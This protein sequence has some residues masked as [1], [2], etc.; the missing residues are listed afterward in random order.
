LIRKLLKFTG[1]ITVLAIL[2][3]GSLFVVSP[4]YVYQVFNQELPVGRLE[5][6]LTDELEYLAMLTEGSSCN[7]TQYRIL[8]DQF[9]LD[10]G[11]VKW[12][13]PAVLLGFKP[14]YRLDRL[15][16]RY[17]E[18]VQ[19]NSM[20]TLAHDL[21]PDLLFDFFDD[22][23]SD[24]ENHWLID[25]TYGSSVYHDIDPLLTYTILATEDGL[26]LRTTPLFEY[27]SNSD[28]LVIGISSACA[29]NPH[30]KFRDILLDMNSI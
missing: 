18:T 23:N 24:S 8:G 3:V 25:T 27:E 2:S 29:N 13:G 7:Q 1:V 19:Q 30:A 10:A 11:F 14:R 4:F 6:Q 12:K 15:S 5:F 16:G 9:Q 22:N 17:R 28:L 21:A 26:I 20:P